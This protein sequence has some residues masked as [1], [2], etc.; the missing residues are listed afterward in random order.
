M[1]VNDTLTLPETDVQTV[2]NFFRSKRREDFLASM[3]VIRESLAAGSWIQPRGAQ[4]AKKGIS[5]GFGKAQD[6]CLRYD[7]PRSE[8]VFRC[9]MTIRHGSNLSQSELDVI[10][11]DEISR[12]IPKAPIEAVR[13]WLRLMVALTA[14]REDLD[15]SRPLPVY[16][17]IGVSP[18]VTKTLQDAEID[19]DL[20]TRR[21]C[22]VG[23]YWI[24]VADENG[25]ER[26]EKYYFPKW[27][28]NTKF[29]SSRFAGCDCEA[30]GKTIPSKRYVP[31]VIDNKQG[32]PF[33]FWFGRDCAAN[34]LGIKDIGLQRSEP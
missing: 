8:P 20:S 14:I 23:W 11:D 30:C 21:V 33:G 6:L 10:T 3:E 5:K 31:V 7:D 27:P 15:A 34:I 22:P 9:F 28:S 2:A 29:G 25:R 18:K 13:A 24:V 16:T 26:R 1:S 17:E 12:I 19:L 4:R 32:V